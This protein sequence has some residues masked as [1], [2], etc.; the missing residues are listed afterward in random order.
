MNLPS[1]DK[2]GNSYLSY[3][4]ISTFLKDKEQFIKTY[5][6]KEP[7]IGNA[8]TDFGSRVGKAL[9]ENDF[10]L[11]TKKEESTLKKVNRFDE[12]ERK[13]ILNYDA[14]YL[15][16]YVD[17]NTFDLTEIKDYKTGGAGKD[18]QYSMPEYTQ[19][20]YYALGIRQETGINVKKATVEF[21]QRDGNLH[22]GLKVS[23]TPPKV[24]D[25]DVSEQRLKYVYWD[26]IRIAKEIEAFYNKYL[27][28]NLQVMK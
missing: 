6:L 10:C 21:I 17:T 23:E 15:I 4:S 9:E 22:S 11:F 25:I 8:Y 27:L 1:K 19:L 12:F 3:S 5:I 16:G 26:T 14:F 28:T 7:F 2:N 18:L 13:I 20:C 24:I